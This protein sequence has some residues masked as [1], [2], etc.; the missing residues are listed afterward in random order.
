MLA[1]Q[2]VPWK[3]RIAAITGHHS[4]FTSADA[5]RRSLV[6]HTHTIARK[7]PCVRRLL[8]INRSLGEISRFPL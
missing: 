8:K 7:G 6:H 1:F 2:R 5:F 3:P 4:I